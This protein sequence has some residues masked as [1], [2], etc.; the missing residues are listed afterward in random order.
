MGCAPIYENTERRAV[1][2]Q[3]VLAVVKI[4]GSLD[5]DGRIYG[6]HQ[7]GR[8]LSPAANTFT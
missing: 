5:A 7:G 1:G 8:H 4:D 2:A 6:S 3:L